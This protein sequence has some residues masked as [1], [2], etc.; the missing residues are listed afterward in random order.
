MDIIGYLKYSEMELGIE[1]LKMLIK[2]GESYIVE[3]LIHLQKS[4]Q[5][6]LRS[7]R[8]YGNT[9]SDRRGLC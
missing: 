9:K 5:A 6:T 2:R 3:Y 7:M 1:E 8:D 4:M